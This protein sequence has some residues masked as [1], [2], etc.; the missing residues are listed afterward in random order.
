MPNTK[1]IL[2]YASILKRSACLLAS[3]SEAANKNNDRSKYVERIIESIITDLENSRGITSLCEQNTYKFIT[4]MS[5]T[6]MADKYYEYPLILIEYYNEYNADKANA[7]LNEF[8]S[9][10][11]PRMSNLDSLSEALSRHE[12]IFGN[13]REL[14]QE[15][16][17]QYTI[18]DRILENHNTISKRFN[19]ENEV[20][21]LS[22]ANSNKKGIINNCCSMIDTYNL[23]AYQKFNICIEEMYYLTNKN[24]S[25]IELSDMVKYISEYFLM[26]NDIL[27]SKDMRG[28]RKALTESSLLT[29]ED[30]A[31]VSFIVTNDVTSGSMIRQ[32]IQS[33]LIAPEKSIELFTKTINLC[34]DCDL[35]DLS[36]NLGELLIFICDAYNSELYDP[37][38]M[39]EALLSWVE[40]LELKLSI[41]LDSDNN[42]DI[43][44]KEYVNDIFKQIEKAANYITCNDVNNSSTIAAAIDTIKKQLDQI[45]ST[46]YTESNI[47]TI[48]YL[49]SDDNMPILT[50]ESKVF[51]KYNII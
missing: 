45:N 41:A 38:D 37:D 33:Y 28:I 8:V 35:I 9:S 32:C 29:E 17:K 34:L 15:T 31:S 26:N 51:K 40:K 12:L 30:T 20:K 44:T 23:P 11:I 16:I 25:H 22:Y 39:D 21:K 7:F 1:S 19:I 2:N 42:I 24:K 14:I 43:I 49:N 10:I 3:V 27:T 13:Q 47:A 46:I 6:A 18:I 48:E 50:S 5:N 36:N 4:E